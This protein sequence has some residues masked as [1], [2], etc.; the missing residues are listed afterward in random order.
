MFS[1]APKRRGTRWH[2]FSGCWSS[3]IPLIQ[4]VCDEVGSTHPCRY[5]RRTYGAPDVWD[6]REVVLGSQ[7]QPQEDRGNS[8]NHE[9]PG[10][11]ASIG[12][13]GPGKSDRESHRAKASRLPL[14]A[15]N[16]SGEESCKTD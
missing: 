5:S 1:D 16:G 13:C 15:R 10:D 6:T 7:S 11:S 3:L 9:G 8:G 2:A 4:E 12:G 14:G